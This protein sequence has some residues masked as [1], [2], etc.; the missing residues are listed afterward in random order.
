MIENQ[1]IGEANN[2]SIVVAELNST[3]RAILASA[4][5]SLEHPSLASRLGNMI[6]SPIEIGFHIL[7]RQ[8]YRRLHELTERTIFATLSAAISTLDKKPASQ[9]RS[10]YHKTLSFATGGVSGFFGLPALLIEL[11][12]TTTLMLRSIA[13]IA[14]SYGEDLKQIETRIACLQVF[15]LSGRTHEDDATE[16][17]YYGMRLALSISMFNAQDR[18]MKHG[19]AQSPVM[20][21]MISFIAQRFGVQVQQKTAAKMVPIVG[22]LSS[23]AINVIFMQHFQQIAHAH[24]AIRNLERKYGKSLVQAEYEKLTTNDN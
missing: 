19:L 10:G 16:S 15:A 21:R 3:D 17:G 11:P 24:F 13:D 14:Q 23:A 2:H 6:G 18:I 5:E 1:Q 22:A 9:P 8:W 4:Y 7:P 12:I 20:I